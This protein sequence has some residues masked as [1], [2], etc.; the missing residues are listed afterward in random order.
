MDNLTVIRE[1]LEYYINVALED[2]PNLPAQKY[3]DAL[4]A[5]SAIEDDI[6]R[7]KGEIGQLVIERETALQELKAREWQDIS[8]AP[9]DG[10]TVF[11]WTGNAEFP[12][13]HEATWRVPT[14][15]E[16]WVNGSSEPNFTEGGTFGPEEGW[17]DECGY[18]HKLQGSE[19]P[20]H[21]QPMPNK[22]PSCESTNGEG[23]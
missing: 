6:Q 19:L 20:T 2:N 22:P 4:T 9:R 14:E 13:R 18:T 3:R 1:A 21:W 7:M 11:V 16:Y 10:T 5:L 17:F 23:V 12:M 15:S 8:T